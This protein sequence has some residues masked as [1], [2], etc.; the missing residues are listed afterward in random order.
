MPALAAVQVL[1]WQGQ[2]ARMT[3]TGTNEHSLQTR[4]SLKNHGDVSC[5]KSAVPEENTIPPCILQVCFGRSYSSQLILRDLG[6]EL[7]AYSPKAMDL[8]SAAS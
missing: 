4:P 1:H 7:E 3:S 2:Q 5:F 6:F 8:H